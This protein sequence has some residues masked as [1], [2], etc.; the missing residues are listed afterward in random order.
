MSDVYTT[1]DEKFEADVLKADEPVL[2]DFWAEWCQPC[3]M[4]APMVE[5]IAEIYK[6]RIKVFKVNVDKNTETPQ[7][8]GIQGI[9]SLLVFRDGEV[10]ATKV[11][12]LSKLQLAT[13]LD[14]NLHFSS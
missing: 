7:K 2:V 13:F 14:E 11:G 6:G 9:P 1:S 3:K 10:V 8:Y 5:E 12:M 4:I